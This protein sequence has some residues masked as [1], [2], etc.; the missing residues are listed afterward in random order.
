[1]IYR[2]PKCV[3]VGDS[4]GLA[5]VVALWLT[6]HGI[7]AEVTNPATLGGLDGLTWLSRNAVSASGIEVWVQEP[8]QA[9]Q[10]RQLV[11]QHSAE[12]AAK[13]AERGTAGDIAVVC[14]ACGEENVFLGSE[15]GKVLSCESC[16]EYIDVPDPSAEAEF[17][18]G[19]EATEES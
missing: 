7:A 1:M 17:T 11:A 3:F 8:A 19:E 12:L 15:A 6:D 4:L 18:D 14:E 5:E 2:D 9:E 13:A 10:A 16:G